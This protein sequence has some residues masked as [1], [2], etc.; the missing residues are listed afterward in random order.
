MTMSRCA[1]NKVS[2]LILIST[3]FPLP[4]KTSHLTKKTLISNNPPPP[5]HTH[6]HHMP[7][8]SN[9]TNHLPVCSPIPKKYPL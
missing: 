8:H 4:Q 2:Y 1:S 3:T 6:T 9:L 5:P 7:N